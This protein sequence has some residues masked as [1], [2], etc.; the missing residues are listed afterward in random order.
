MS[1]QAVDHNSSHALSR[2]DRAERIT[3]V[4]RMPPPGPRPVTL[5]RHPLD[6]IG[7]QPP[8]I[9][10]A[11][12]L[13]PVTELDHHQPGVLVPIRPPVC[14][15]VI[16]HHQRLD[17]RVVVHAAVRLVNNGK[18]GAPS[19]MGCFTSTRW[20]KIHICVADS[21]TCGHASGH[22]GGRLRFRL[23]VCREFRPR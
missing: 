8:E 18:R 20:I 13:G 4:H 17:V 9:L 19:R 23:D 7:N 10:V 2:L 11:K 14:L 22:A 6:R 1:P 16:R 21:V 3:G 12:D 5:A 15:P